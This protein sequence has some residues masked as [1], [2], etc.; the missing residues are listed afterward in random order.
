MIVALGGKAGSGKS[1]GAGCITERYGLERVAFADPIKAELRGELSAAGV[2]PQTIERML[3]GDLKEVPALALG[4]R[5]S[6]QAFRDKGDAGKAAHGFDYWTRLWRS[7]VERRLSRGAKGIVCDDIR[8]AWEA[9]EVRSLGGIVIR[10]VNPRTVGAVADHSSEAEEYRPDVTIW[11]DGP[12][13]ILAAR[14]DGVIERWQ[15]AAA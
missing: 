9:D 5:T 15:R 13:F 14:L 1:T 3:Y 10:L 8:Y 11:N 2:D 12:V 6:R 4:G 7:D